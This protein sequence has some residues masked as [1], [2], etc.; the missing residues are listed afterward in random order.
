MLASFS[1]GRLVT[2]LRQYKQHTI[3]GKNTPKMN[4]EVGGGVQIILFFLYFVA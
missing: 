3:T 2:S 4:S 1:C